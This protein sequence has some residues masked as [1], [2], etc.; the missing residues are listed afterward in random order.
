MLEAVEQRERQARARGVVTG[1]SLGLLV[2]ATL[3][4]I[5]VFQWR[6][7]EAAQAELEAMLAEL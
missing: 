3:G 2:V 4:V 1:L 5:T 7:A 6:A